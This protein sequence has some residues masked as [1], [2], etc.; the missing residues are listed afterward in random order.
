M[1][2][3]ERQM[4]RLRRLRENGLCVKCSK[5]MDRKGQLCTECLRRTNEESREMYHWYQDNGICPTCRKNIILGEEKNCLEC[6]A[7]KTNNA[8]KRLQQDDGKLLENKKQCDKNRYKARKERG[9][10]VVCG[11]N[12]Q[13]PTYAVCKQCRIKRNRK[14]NDRRKKTIGIELRRCKPL[15]G[16][17]Y[18][19]DNPIMPGRTICKVHYEFYRKKAETDESFKKGRAEHLEKIKWHIAPTNKNKEEKGYF[20]ERVKKPQE[21]KKMG[22]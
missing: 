11:V 5:E 10:C 3:K 6:R 18:F 21:L 14:R 7:R 8:N 2:S 13:D 1:D 12:N 9:E 15:H 17:C 16:I 20:Y 19:C 22:E 4:K